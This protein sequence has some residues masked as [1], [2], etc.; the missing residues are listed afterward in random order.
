MLWG[1]RK[2]LI[3]YKGL[4]YVFEL[5]KE[6]VLL[7]RS[8]YRVTDGAWYPGRQKGIEPKNRVS[9]SHGKDISSTVDEWMDRYQQRSEWMWLEYGTLIWWSW[10]S[11][12]HSRFRLWYE[13]RLA[14]NKCHSGLHH[15]SR[16]DVSSMRAVFCGTF[17]N[18]SS[19]NHSTW[20]IVSFVVVIY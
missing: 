11:Q 19:A 15:Y 4:E 10:L 6:P 17:L 18:A 1:K 9:L 14:W 16:L 2:V 8:G 13:I 5:R 12:R 3:K 7:S 20:N